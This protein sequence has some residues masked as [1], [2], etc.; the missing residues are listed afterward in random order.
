MSRNVRLSL[1]WRVPEPCWWSKGRAGAGKT[2]TLAAARTALG[3]RGHRLVVVTPTLKAAT[4][5]ARELGSRA[6]SAAWLAHQYGYR[7]DDHGLWTRLEPGQ[8]ESHRDPHTGKAYA[9]PSFAAALAAGDLLLVDEAGM[10]DQDTARALLRI[11]DESGARVAFVGD[12]HQL[13]AVG[14]GGVLDLAV[15]WAA[16][17]G[18]LTLDVVHR[19][20]DPEYARISLAMRTG[21][22]LGTGGEPSGERRGEASG[23]VFDALLARDQIRIYP[24]QAERTQA[25][26]GLRAASIIARRARCT[27][28]GLD[29]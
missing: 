24:T 9:G 23:G 25:L 7:W 10:L 8:H 27:G 19:F 26:A 22:P 12:R 3:E 2:T 1:P 15:R 17:Q 16:S 11:A 6:F 4:V 21:E 13:P 5:A 29:P 18:C 14:R 20:S 28:D